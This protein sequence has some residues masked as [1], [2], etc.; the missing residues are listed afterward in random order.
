MHLDVKSDVW[1]PEQC[2]LEECCD[3]LTMLWAAVDV[4]ENRLRTRLHS[5][6]RDAG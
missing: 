4:V 1:E 2:A 3:A 6:D 5:V